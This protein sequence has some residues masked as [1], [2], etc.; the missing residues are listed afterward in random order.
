MN[1]F[2]ILESNAVTGLALAG[3]SV[4]ISDS[5]L[6]SALAGTGVEVVVGFVASWGSTCM[7]HEGSFPSHG[8]PLA[9]ALEGMLLFSLR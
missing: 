4:S 9:A 7:G 6:S 8:A 5:L 3:C 1:F 2:W